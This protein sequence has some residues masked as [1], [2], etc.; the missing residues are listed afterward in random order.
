MEELSGK[1]AIVTGGGTGIGRGV[2][3]MLAARGCKVLLCGRRKAPLEETLKVIQEP[4]SY[5]HLT[6]PTM[7]TTWGGGWG[8][9]G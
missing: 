7:S 6:L 3:V 8:G 2:A 5:T 9:G 4:V 1:V